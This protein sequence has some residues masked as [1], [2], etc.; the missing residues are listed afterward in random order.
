MANFE[1]KSIIPGKTFQE[2]NLNSY[3]LF[4]CSSANLFNSNLIFIYHKNTKCSIK[5]IRF[6]KSLLL[7]IV[8]SNGVSGYHSK[9]KIKLKNS[10]GI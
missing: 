1:A 4:N 3:F 6:H 2:V 7:S 10:K 5:D 9:L 8:S